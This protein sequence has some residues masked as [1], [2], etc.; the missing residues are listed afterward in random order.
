MN[1]KKDKPKN[2][3]TDNPETRF[4]Q[5]ARALMAVP[6]K[7]IDKELEKHERRKETANRKRSKS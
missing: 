2:I 7:E 3:P 4:Y 6:K 1:N 5:F